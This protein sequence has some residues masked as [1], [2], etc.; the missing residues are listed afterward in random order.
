MINLSYK[1]KS[2]LALSGIFSVLALLYA[3]DTLEQDVN[4]NNPIVNLT[5]NEV[6]AISN[7]SAYID[8]YSR[9]NTSGPVRFDISSKPKHGNLSEVASGLLRYSP[10]T[11]F[12][13]GHD[14]FAFSIYSTNDKLLLRDSIIITVGDSTDA[15]CNFYPKDDWVYTSGTPV[16]VNVL[17]NDFLCGDTSD[18]VLEIY[19][20]GSNFPP[21][22]GSA[23]VI[24]GNKIQ[25]TAF[26]KSINTVDTVVYKLSR[27]GDRSTVGFGTVY[28]NVNVD[29]ANECQPITDS[30]W[31]ALRP[32]PVADTMFIIAYDSSNFCNVTY[33]SLTI[34][35]Q[36]KNGSAIPF[37]NMYIKYAY[38]LT[39]T[40]QVLLD[41]LTYNLCNGQGCVDGNIYIRIN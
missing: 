4:P 41:T 14:S 10:A 28:I 35:S 6:F 39:D 21:H 12:K 17:G 30:L 25:Y 40:N 5:S 26:N 22:S 16:N 11:T 19:K 7:R 37:M 29:T 9:I 3:C 34:T 38:T 15:P 13:S 23:S 24:S 27:S 1:V 18:I 33:D 20:P 36:P 32:D 8:L 31:T 2:C